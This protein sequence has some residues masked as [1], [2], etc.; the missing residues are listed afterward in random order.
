ML[1]IYSYLDLE[2]HSFGFRKD[3][4]SCGNLGSF[5]RIGFVTCSFY[6]HTFKMA[7]TEYFYSASKENQN[8]C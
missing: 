2:L 8:A 5:S 7:R 3:H 4:H 1:L 6:R